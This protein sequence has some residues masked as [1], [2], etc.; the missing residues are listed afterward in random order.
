MNEKRKYMEF[1][2]F[3]IENTAEALGVSGAEV[4]NTLSATDGISGFLYPSYP[5]LHTQGKEYIVNEVLTY[6][7]QHNQ[8]IGETQQSDLHSES[9]YSG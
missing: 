2:V 4:Y 8:T 7:K 9:G 6:L 3:C 1:I 5:T